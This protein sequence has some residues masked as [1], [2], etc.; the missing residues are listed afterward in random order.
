MVWLCLLGYF[1]DTEREIYWMLVPC[2]SVLTN[3]SFSFAN[4]QV[5]LLW[6]ILFPTQ[7][8]KQRKKKRKKK[9]TCITLSSDNCKFLVSSYFAFNSYI[10]CI[11][12]S[13]NCL[14]DASSK[15]SNRIYLYEYPYTCFCW[16]SIDL[17]IPINSI[18]F[19]PY[20]VFNGHPFS[21]P[22]F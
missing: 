3:T 11:I 15:K 20:S 18:F 19:F 5:K 14:S 2:T 4:Q 8:N 21:S 16:K 10:Q 13:V 22:L 17:Y 9:P 1:P 7:F 6:L 12:T